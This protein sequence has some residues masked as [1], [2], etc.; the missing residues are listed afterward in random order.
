ME[1]DMGKQTLDV[2]TTRR[3]LY[4]LIWLGV[5]VVYTIRAVLVKTGRADRWNS[6]LTLVSMSVTAPP[7][8]GEKVTTE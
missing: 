1:P 6:R 2:I 4:P 8:G 3:W 7:D 5:D